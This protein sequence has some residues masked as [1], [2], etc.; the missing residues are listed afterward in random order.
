MP[1]SHRPVLLVP[2]LAC[3]NFGGLT[4]FRL[5]RGDVLGVGLAC[6]EVDGTMRLR[7][8]RKKLRSMEE[9]GF[10]K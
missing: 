6:I 2:T 3:K 4:S 1:R 5:H 7:G 10:G 8:Q 9:Y